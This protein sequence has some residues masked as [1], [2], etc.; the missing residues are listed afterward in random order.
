MRNS[1]TAGN[2]K[3]L[4]QQRTAVWQGDTEGLTSRAKSVDMW[5]PDCTPCHSILFVRARG[6]GIG[7]S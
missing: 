4:L 3:P 1:C 7:V 6:I 5:N 2:R